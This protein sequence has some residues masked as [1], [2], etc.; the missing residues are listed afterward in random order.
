MNE[1]RKEAVPSN[2]RGVRH[3]SFKTDTEGEQLKNTG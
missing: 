3:R 1:H 2:I